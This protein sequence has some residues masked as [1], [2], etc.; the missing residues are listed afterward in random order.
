MHENAALAH[1]IKGIRIVNERI[2]DPRK[3][4]DDFNIQAAL[5]MSG[6]E[7]LISPCSTLYDS[8]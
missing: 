2:S 6:I 3:G 1:K 7:V 4:P 5:V 8:P